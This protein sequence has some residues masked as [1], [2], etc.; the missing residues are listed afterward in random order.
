MTKSKVVEYSLEQQ[1]VTFP[2]GSKRIT[3]LVEQQE[4]LQMLI[5]QTI[6][7]HVQHNKPFLELYH[8]ITDEVK[9]QN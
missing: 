9:L 5:I 4:S 3:L 1:I 7:E 6:M 8:P 2:Y